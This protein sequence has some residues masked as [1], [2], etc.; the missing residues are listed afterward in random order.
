MKLKDKAKAE[1]DCH[2]QKWKEMQ[3]KAPRDPELA[4]RQKIAK[5]MIERYGDALRRLAEF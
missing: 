1:T 5:H 2:N 3:E 4:E